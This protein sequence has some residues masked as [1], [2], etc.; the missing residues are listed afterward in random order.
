MD[1]NY[2]HIMRDQDY[3]ILPYL[4]DKIKIKVFYKYDGI[5]QNAFLTMLPNAFII[6]GG[7]SG[8]TNMGGASY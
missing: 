1:V 2:A 7:I 3:I 6:E 8:H 5:L 4:I